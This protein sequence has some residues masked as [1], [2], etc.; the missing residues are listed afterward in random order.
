[1]LKAE[2]TVAVTHSGSFPD[3]VRVHGGYLESWIHLFFVWL[4]GF[5]LYQETWGGVSC[6]LM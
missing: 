5:M 2:V 4:S 3:A 6:D 1:M